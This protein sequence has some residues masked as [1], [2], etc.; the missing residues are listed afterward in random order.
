MNLLHNLVYRIW[1]T[2][3]AMRLGSD[4]LRAQGHA[5]PARLRRPRDRRSG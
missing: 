4:V 5:P 1:W 3:H 2:W